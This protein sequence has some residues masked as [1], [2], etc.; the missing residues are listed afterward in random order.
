MNKCEPRELT[1]DYTACNSSYVHSENMNER[2]FCGKR[3]LND[4]ALKGFMLL[5]VMS[6]NVPSRGANSACKMVPFKN[7]YQLHLIGLKNN[8][9]KMSRYQ[10]AK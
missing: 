10:C 5:I 4:I 8:K 2:C 7:M 1:C 9:T 6:L 3:S